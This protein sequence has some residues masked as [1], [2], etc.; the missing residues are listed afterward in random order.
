MEKGSKLLQLLLSLVIDYLRWTQITP[1]ILMWAMVIGMLF[2]LLFVS[3]EEAVWS[4]VG[5]LTRWIASLPWIG[6]EFTAFMESQAEDG[7]IKPDLGAIDYK[8]VILRVWGGFALMFMV[9]AWVASLFLGPFEPWTLKRKLVTAALACTIVVAIMMVLYFLDPGTWND[10]PLM[11]ALSASGMAL[12]M[13]IVNAWC[14]SVSHALG[15]V[16]TY[17][18]EADLGQHDASGGVS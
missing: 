1:I 9:I 16:S 10:G 7:V 6:P 3:H 17:V 2:A 18:A 5:A 11:V 4:V 15:L 12:V 14:L 13:F 8:S